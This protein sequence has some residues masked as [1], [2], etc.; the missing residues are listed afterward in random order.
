MTQIGIIRRIEGDRVWVEVNHSERR[1]GEPALSCCTDASATV[2]AFN[3]HNHDIEPGDSVK[4]ISSSQSI[5]MTILWG[6]VI[7]LFAFFIAYIVAGSAF[8]ITSEAGKAGLGFAGL[9]IGCIAPFLYFR[10]KKPADKRPIIM[11]IS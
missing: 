9:L 7:P 3:S 1:E 4:L 10:L 8:K 11:P 5:A 6:L 2:E